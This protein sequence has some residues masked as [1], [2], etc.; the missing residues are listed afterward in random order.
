MFPTQLDW[1]DFTLNS[2]KNDKDAHVFIRI[3]PAEVSSKNDLILT[4]KN[5]GSTLIPLIESIIIKNNIENVTFIQPEDNFSSYKLLES[6][7]ASLIYGSKICLESAYRNI[8][9]II[10]GNSLFRQHQFSYLPSSK[11]HYSSLLLNPIHPKEEQVEYSLRFAHY[12]YY[13][14]FRDCSWAEDLAN[15]RTN[16][17][18]ISSEALKVIGDTLKLGSA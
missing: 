10:C 12:V 13:R 8:P 11:S 14:V 18:D 16:F 7:Y 17:F 9:T 2:L 6:S 1:I 15:P 4:K 3:H 5:F